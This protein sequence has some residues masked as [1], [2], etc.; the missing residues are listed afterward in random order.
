MPPTPG[1]RTR[2]KGAARDAVA[3]QLRALLLG[4]AFAGR[5]VNVPAARALIKAGNRLFAE[6]AAFAG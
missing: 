5:P 6:A 1:S 2:C 4:A 3:G